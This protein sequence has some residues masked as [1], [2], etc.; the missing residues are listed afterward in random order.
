MPL[1]G[2]ARTHWPVA[3]WIRLRLPPAP[4][5]MLLLGSQPPPAAPPLDILVPSPVATDPRRR[6]FAFEEER[7]GGWILR[8]VWDAED[9]G[10][11][12]GEYRAPIYRSRLPASEVPRFWAAVKERVAPLGPLAVDSADPHP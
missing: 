4:P 1:L 3:A 9:P 11:L 8:L 6:I 10:I 5:P 12:E 7:E 2:A